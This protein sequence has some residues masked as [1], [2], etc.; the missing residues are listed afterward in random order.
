MVRENKSNIS[1]SLSEKRLSDNPFVVFSEWLQQAE[2]GGVEMPEA[3][4]LS[5]IDANGNPS[6]RMVLLR[7]M[8][9]RGFIFYTN[10]H[11]R[12]S[13]EIERNHKVSLLFYWETLGRQVRIEGM[14]EK[15][16]DE[17]SDG[18]FRT[19]PR[20]NQIAA[21]A[22]DQSEPVP[23]RETL[24]DRFRMMKK[25]FSGKPVPRPPHWGGYLV[26]P[27]RFEFWQQGE[28]RLHDRIVY[29]LQSDGKW[30]RYRLY[31]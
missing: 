1:K 7:G 17:V 24:E 18:Y 29:E 16:S 27:R 10:Y 3:M 13:R 30:K 25:K 21:W 9:E 15:V 28:H 19:R 23:D 31:P 11:S 5:T 14:A 4:V 26:I 6:S 20:E 2:S 8:N 12:K 22:S